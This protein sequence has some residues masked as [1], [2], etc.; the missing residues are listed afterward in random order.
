MPPCLAV[1]ESRTTKIKK[2]VVTR[3]FIKDTPVSGIGGNLIHSFMKQGA[4]WMEV[5]GL[6]LSRNYAK[7]WTPRNR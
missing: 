5:S 3:G 7:I 6:Y 2:Y 4:L 1:V